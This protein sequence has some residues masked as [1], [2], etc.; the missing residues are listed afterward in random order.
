[1]LTFVIK[2]IF[3]VI[4]LFSQIFSNDLIEDL[5]S[6]HNQLLS[7]FTNI[8]EDIY[9]YEFATEYIIEN[10]LS[11]VFN[12]S[13]GEFNIIFTMAINSPDVFLNIDKNKFKKYKYDSEYFT[14]LKKKIS[15][16]QKSKIINAFTIEDVNESSVQL[17]NTPYDFFKDK[18]V[19]S[20]NYGP[21]FKFGLGSNYQKYSNGSSFNLLIY[22]P[23]TI[24]F[25][26]RIYLLAFDL[27][28]ITVPSAS[29]SSIRDYNTNSFN[30]HLINYLDKVPIK[31]DFSLGIANNKKYELGFLFESSL[32]YELEFNP[33]NLSFNLEYTKHI[34]FTDDNKL[35][36]E[37]LDLIGFNIK[38]IKKIQFK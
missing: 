36:F 38:L 6:H 10:E 8:Q 11:D 37:A 25:F 12:Y 9:D 31:L 30:V 28:T 32:S 15:N 1:M 33:I 29:S 24:L 14:E 18:L 35:D 26:Q 21:S 7:I 13:L 4:I 16:K 19:F 27:K 2:Y 3:F 17:I 34:D 23:D 22:H 5:S 20:I